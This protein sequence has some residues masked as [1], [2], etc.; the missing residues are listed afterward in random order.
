MTSPKEPNYFA[1]SL[2]T[3]R[4]LKRC[5]EFRTKLDSYLRLFDRATEK[6]VRRGEA[7][8]R[9]LRCEPALKEIKALCP[10]ARLI[11]MVR[12]PVEMVQSWHAQKLWEKQETETNL[13]RA[14]RLEASRRRC[15]H[16]PRGLK[17]KDALFYSTVSCLGT[18]GE[19]LLEI[20]RREQV[21]FALLDDLRDDPLQVYQDALRFLELADDGRTDFSVQNPRR[22][23]VTSRIMSALRIATTPPAQSTISSAFESELRDYFKP[24]TR[25]LERILGR[26]LSAWRRGTKG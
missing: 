14:W 18:Q 13:E 8:T 23:S 4:A 16:L 10:D 19:R 6:H 26:D 9:Y 5:E 7:S 12:D 22:T 25:K 1:R 3:D 15:E 11:V 21:W 17:A 24:E 2:F 20:V